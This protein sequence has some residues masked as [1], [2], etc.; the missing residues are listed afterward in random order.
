MLSG[1]TTRSLRLNGM[2]VRFESVMRR[3]YAVNEGSCV[4]RIKIQSTLPP[5]RQVSHGHAVLFNFH[6]LY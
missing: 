1:V 2:F 4:S 3:D 6:V 5:F